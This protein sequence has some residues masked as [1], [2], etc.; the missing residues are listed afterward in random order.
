MSVG[1][2]EEDCD[3]RYKSRHS[4]EDVASQR[5]RDAGK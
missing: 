1:I 4:L 5:L 2:E 3:E